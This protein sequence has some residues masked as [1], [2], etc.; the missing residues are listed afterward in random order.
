MHPQRSVWNQFWKSI[1]VQNCLMGI[2]TQQGS[3]KKK[4]LGNLENC[5]LWLGSGLELKSINQG[6]IWKTMYMWNQEPC[7]MKS[8][9]KMTTTLLKVQIKCK[10]LDMLCCIYAIYYWDNEIVGRKTTSDPVTLNQVWLILHLRLLMLLCVLSQNGP[11]L[12]REK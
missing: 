9:V 2:Q 7:F 4:D 8:Y 11:L 5:G 6:Y 10:I 1:L 12:V 3:I